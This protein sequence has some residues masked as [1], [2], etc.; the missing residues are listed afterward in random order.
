MPQDSE[1]FRQVRCNLYKVLSA[2]ANLDIYEQN[3]RINKLNFERTKAMFDEGLKSKI[4]VVNAEVNL[5]DSKI[6]L[7]EGRNALE[8]AIIALQ[9][10]M[11]YQ[12]DT[13][14]I[15]QNTENFNFLKSDYK[16]KIQ[17]H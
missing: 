8:T 4:D 15:V 16:Q 3:V 5:T 1:H 6:Q 14:F 10:S 17:G 11:F 12:E 2:L 13:P 7:V 9:N